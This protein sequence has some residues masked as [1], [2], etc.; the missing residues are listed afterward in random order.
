[1][2]TE[3][4]LQTTDPKLTIGQLFNANI[5]PKILASVLFHTI[6]YAAF[7]NIASYVF[8]GKMLFSAVNMRLISVLLVIMFFGFFARFYHVKEI[9]RA[10]GGDANKTR[11]HLDKLY[12]GWIFLS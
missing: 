4:Y 1:M 10:Y 3:L 11:E 6:I 8:T 7:L 5:F 2:L 12:V 9:Y